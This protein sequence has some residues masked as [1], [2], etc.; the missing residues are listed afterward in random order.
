MY[1]ISIYGCAMFKKLVCQ[2]V[3]HKGRFIFGSRSFLQ[4]P[5]TINTWPSVLTCSPTSVHDTSSQIAISL[6]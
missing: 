2:W 6:P 4:T 1:K 5:I 3:K